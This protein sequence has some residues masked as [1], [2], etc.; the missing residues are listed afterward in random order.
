M[1]Y[2]KQTVFAQL[3][4]L[5]THDVSRFYTLCGE[6]LANYKLAVVFQM[7]FPGMPSIFYGDEQGIAGELEAED[8]LTQ[9]MH[10]NCAGASKAEVNVAAELWAQAAGASKITYK[11]NPRIK[12]NMAVG[13]SFI[14]KD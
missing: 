12:Q 4:V 7:T 6:N 14:R 3:N 5:D 11:G 10:L 2:R 8:L 13:G 9:V 1:R